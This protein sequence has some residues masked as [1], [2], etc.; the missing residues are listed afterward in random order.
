[1]QLLIITVFSNRLINVNINN[2]NISLIIR[3]KLFFFNINQKRLIIVNINFVNFNFN[4]KIMFIRTINKID[5]ENFLYFIKIINDLF[6]KI[7]KLIQN[8]KIIN[9]DLKFI[10]TIKKTFVFCC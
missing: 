10:K 9:F 3:D 6:I 1:M 4:I 8:I 2:K 7:I 5:R